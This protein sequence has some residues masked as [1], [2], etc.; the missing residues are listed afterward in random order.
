MKCAREPPAR[1][2]ARGGS[3]SVAAT[4]L[5]PPGGDV[6]NTFNNRRGRA[7]LQ[8]RVAQ[9]PASEHLPWTIRMSDPNARTTAPA[10][11]S[12][13]QLLAQIALGNRA[14]FE[15]LYHS[16]AD[17][18]FGICVRVLSERA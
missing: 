3:V 4:R 13:E 11:S 17:K 5:P 14:A 6:S 10:G 12:L 2:R 1:H 7:A 8:R 15:S 18:L 9:P 16:T